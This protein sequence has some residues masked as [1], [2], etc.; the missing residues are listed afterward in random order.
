[1]EQMILGTRDILLG[2]IAA[3]GALLSILWR[4]LNGRVDAVEARERKYATRE[5]LNG[6]VGAL[7][8]EMRDNHKDVTERL[9]KLIQRG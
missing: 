6:S 1:M 9:D 7:R 4:R 5:E 8:S 2:A 3:I